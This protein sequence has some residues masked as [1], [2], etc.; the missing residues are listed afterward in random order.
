MRTID[1]DHPKLLEPTFKE[2]MTHSPAVRQFLRDAV[3]PWL[4]PVY[5]FTNS[6]HCLPMKV[7][8]V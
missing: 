1:L 2:G 4:L 6:P 5:L 8:H 3:W 7:S